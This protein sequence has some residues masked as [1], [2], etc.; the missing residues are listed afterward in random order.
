[1]SAADVPG[2]IEKVKAKL[3]HWKEDQAAQTQRVSDILTYSSS[4]Y[5]V[6]WLTF[7]STQN[8]E[9]A[10]KK[11]EELEKAE[12]NGEKV[13]EVTEDLK[14]ASLEDKEKQEES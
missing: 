7:K 11:L 6:S 8:I 13:D 4:L 5:D 9:K 3:E 1:M 14:D 2:V 10:K 12:A